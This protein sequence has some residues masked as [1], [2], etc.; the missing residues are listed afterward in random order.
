MNGRI[1]LNNRVLKRGGLFVSY[2]HHDAKWL[3]RIS[4]M[5]SP[6]IREEA[7]QV[8]DD[9]RIAPGSHWRGAINGAIDR[10]Q[11]ALLLVSPSFLASRFIADEE[12]PPLL[13]AAREE[14][15]VILWVL[16][17]PCLYAK[18][19]IAEFQAAH[20]I[21]NPWTACRHH[22]AIKNWYTLRR[23]SQ[24]HCRTQAQRVVAQSR[25]LLRAMAVAV[26]AAP[27]CP[28]QPTR[29]RSLDRG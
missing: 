7:I 8:W 26:E 20:N 25:R 22:A 18:T 23:S 29:G 16:V 14:G 6:L 15:L 5:L 11:V 4:T 3:G 2:S 1:H 28:M 9:T 27:N 13:R 10:A 21:P 12:L 19:A 24:T 17:S